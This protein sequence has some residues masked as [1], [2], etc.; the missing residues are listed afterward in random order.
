MNNRRS[1]SSPDDQAKQG[2]IRFRCPCAAQRRGRWDAARTGACEMAE[3][4]WNSSLDRSRGLGNYAAA[5][6]RHRFVCQQ[7][8]LCSGSVFFLPFLVFFSFFCFFFVGFAAGFLF[9]VDCV[10]TSAPADGRMWGG[11]SCPTVEN[12]NILAAVVSQLRRRH[13]PPVERSI[14]RLS[15]LNRRTRP[16][17]AALYWSRSEEGSVSDRLICWNGI[18]LLYIIRARLDRSVASA[19][20]D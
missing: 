7:R 5:S 4:E 18:V 2:E 17:R 6:G 1:R 10:P 13:F 16:L 15:S 14:G 20:M 3:I 12:S 19:T 11:R 8:R 9:R